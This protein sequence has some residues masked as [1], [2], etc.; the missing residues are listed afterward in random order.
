[1]RYPSTHKEE[2]RKKLIGSARAIAKRGGFGTTGVDEL[3]ASI[4]SKRAAIHAG[5]A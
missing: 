1:M 5:K 2:T 4:A 3:M